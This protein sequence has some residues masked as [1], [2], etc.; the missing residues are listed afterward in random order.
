MKCMCVDCQRYISEKRT[1][2][3]YL[4]TVQ[5]CWYCCLYLV[6]QVVPSR[7]HPKKDKILFFFSFNIFPIYYLSFKV[8]VLLNITFCLLYNALDTYLFCVLLFLFLSAVS[9][10]HTQIIIINYKFL[11]FCFIFFICTIFSIVLYK[12]LHVLK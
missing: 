4:V 11:I 3:H 12:Y 7:A 9:S 2:Y 6:P 10:V 1:M 5:L 8:C